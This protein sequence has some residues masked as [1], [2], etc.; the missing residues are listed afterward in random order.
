MF[1]GKDLI[2]RQIKKNAFI[3][4]FFIITTVPFLSYIA[5]NKGQPGFDYLVYLKSAVIVLSAFTVSSILVSILCTKLFKLRLSGVML[6]IAT[7]FYLSFTYRAYADALAEVSGYRLIF[8]VGVCV[9]GLFS[10]MMAQRQVFLNGLGVFAVTVILIPLISIFNHVF[11]SST[12]ASLDTYNVQLNNELSENAPIGPPNLY[13]II[14]DAYGSEE[15]LLKY[16]DINISEFTDNLRKRG[17]FIADKSRAPYNM[18]YLS[19]ASILHLEYF[20]D[21]TSESYDRSSAKNIYPRMMR[22][23]TAPVAVQQFRALGYNFLHFGNSWGPCYPVHVECPMPSRSGISYEMLGLLYSTPFRAVASRLSYRLG[24]EGLLGTEALKGLNLFLIENGLPETPTVFFVHNMAPHP[25]Y[26]YQSDCSHRSTYQ[27]DF[28]AWEDEAK[29]LYEAN[30][31][32]VNSR[33]ISLIDKIDSVDP[34]AMII[35]A[36]DHGTAFTGSDSYDERSSTLA[37]ARV[38]EHCGTALTREVNSI[39]LMRIAIACA[40]SVP[41]DL[42]D[43]ITY[44]GTYNSDD[45][46]VGTVWRMPTE[47]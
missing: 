47:N 44:F 32:C 3:P 29:P 1:T 8:V 16:A 31:D 41:P 19:I 14:P 2:E 42:L 43:N 35:I 6:A 12:E 25:P 38:P 23:G 4:L 17:L 18:T 30:L 10:Y 34:D 46:R 28:T 40:S 26:N 21:E 11:F 33:L 22:L 5:T 37:A 13:Y 15:S 39:N 9:S 20:L 27:L 7:M 36:A 24:Y 45:R